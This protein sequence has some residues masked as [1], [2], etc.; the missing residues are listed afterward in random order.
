M[1]GSLLRAQQTSQVCIWAQDLLW[2][3]KQFS[4]HIQNVELES[5]SGLRYTV[6]GNMYGLLE[7][8]RAEL[9]A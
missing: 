1:A 9:K 2:P 4:V 3:V 6:T 7:K 8:G 5:R